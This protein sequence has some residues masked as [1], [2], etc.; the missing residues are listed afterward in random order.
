M[1][2]KGERL[3]IS[4]WPPYDVTPQARQNIDACMGELYKV[5]AATL[6][7]LEMMTGLS[8]WAL[9]AVMRRHSPFDTK[10]KRVKFYADGKW[11]LSSH[12][13][14][15]TMGRKLI[16]YYEDRENIEDGFNSKRF[17]A[18]LPKDLERSIQATEIY[19]S[20]NNMGFG[21][22]VEWINV[23]RVNSFVNKALTMA[24]T[25]EEEVPRVSV[26]GGAMVKSPDGKETLWGMAL[27]TRSSSGFERIL[28][29]TFPKVM[30]KVMRPL[31]LIKESLFA[32]SVIKLRGKIMKGGY[33]YICCV[34]Y[35][36]S[37]NN[38]QVLGA[39]MM[40]DKSIVMREW[41]KEYENRGWMIRRN[42][43]DGKISSDEPYQWMAELPNGNIEFCDTTYGKSLAQVEELVTMI[44]KSGDNRKYSRVLY[45]A[46]EGEKEVWD[47][48]S[49]GHSNMT[50]IE[51]RV[52]DWKF[53][54]VSIEVGKV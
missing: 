49:K 22:Y 7:Q 6:R 32:E 23:A 17:W 37:L 28:Q 41:A 13:G 36:W 35:E 12:T 54:Y 5:R 45:V 21:E 33:G 48:Y 8:H 2:A 25:E 19:A 38:P 34:P 24:R 4:R 20:L 3:T 9:T 50:N 46:T 15:Y 52:I 53:G 47:K 51:Y 11:V 42:Y 16:R 30:G 40:G 43:E 31:L 18:T 27:V 26:M 14:I 29:F 44:R 10:L 1:T 39:F